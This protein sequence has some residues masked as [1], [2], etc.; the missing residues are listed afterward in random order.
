VIILDKEVLIRQNTGK[1]I[2]AE[3]L[4]EVRA[5]WK[6]GISCP[7]LTRISEH[8]VEYWHTVT[9][10]IILINDINKQR[11]YGDAIG[12]G[13]PVTHCQH[14][15]PFSIPEEPGCVLSQSKANPLS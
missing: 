11:S 9:E 12:S 6:E 15:L 1:I 5:V 3:P 4:H 8:L 7:L 13:V 2:D 10:G 14:C